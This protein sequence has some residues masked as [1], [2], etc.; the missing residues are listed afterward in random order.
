MSKKVLNEQTVRRFMKLAN[1]DVL[2]DDFVTRTHE[3]EENNAGKYHQGTGTN[4]PNKVTGRWLK[5]DEAEWGGEDPGMAPE[6]DL[7]PEEGLGEEEVSLTDEQVDILIQL[8]D[9]L[10]AARGPEGEE[11]LGGEEEM[12]PPEE[13]LGAEE[14]AIPGRMYENEDEMIQE[15]AS[16]VAQRMIKE[17]KKRK[18]LKKLDIDKL[19]ERVAR[20]LKREAKKKS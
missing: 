18:M 14:E 8:G 13:E 1:V 2:S 4:D 9:E 16:R 12:L 7:P 5:E 10:K 20:R 3:I 15:I 17:S 11:E 19:T 6:E